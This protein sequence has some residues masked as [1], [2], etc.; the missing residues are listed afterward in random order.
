[1][2]HL[3]HLLTGALWLGSASAAGAVDLPSKPP[4]CAPPP[5]TVLNCG[6]PC[7]VN[8]M[9]SDPTQRDELK[10]AVAR[11]NTTVF[12]GPDVD[13]NFEGL[14]VDWFPITFGRC[15]TLT[16]V[17]TFRTRPDRW[18][19]SERRRPPLFKRQQARSPRSRGPVLRYGRSRGGQAFLHLSCSA[20]VFAGDHA[21]IAGFQLIGP[22]PGQQSTKEIGINVVA[23]KDV[24]I[25]N[26]EISGWAEQ[27]V[28]IRDRAGEDARIDNFGQVVVSDSFIHHNQ[29]PS[30]DGHSGGYGVAVSTGA[31]AT[32]TR[33]V[34]DHNRHSIEA[35][36]DSGGYAAVLNLQLKGG[37]IHQGFL[38]PYTHAFD[39]HGTGNDWWTDGMG[40]DAGELFIYDSNAFQYRKDNAIKIRGKPKKDALITRN[41]FAHPG[42][43]DDWG[44]DAVNLNT[45][46][47]VTLGPGNIINHDTF[48]QYGICDFDGDAIDDLFLA[49]GASFW[50]SSFGE[51]HW[52]FLSDRR[53]QLKDVRLGYFDSDN[54]CDV[55]V[56]DGDQWAYLRSG[57]GAP[58]PLGSF[59]YL[60]KDVVFGRFDPTSRDHRIN[61]TRPTTH[62]FR[63]ETNGQWYVTPLSGANWTPAASSGFPM[64][65]FKFGDFTGDGVTD[66]LAVV[67]GRWHISEGAHGNWRK[68]NN[69]NGDS[70]SGL[71]VANLDADDNVDDLL[72]MS[73]G[74][75]VLSASPRI[76]RV[77]LNWQRSRNGTGRWE[78]LKSYVFTYQAGWEKVT[79]GY[80]MAGRF[81]AAPGGAILTI[82]PDRRGLFYGPSERQVGAN[83]DWS[84]LHPY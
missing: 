27:G 25:G 47:N 23:C 76:V 77:T 15:V 32:I 60:L 13:L 42:F 49:T 37:G 43:E 65:R 48:G 64:D 52:S 34:F 66:V 51:F 44:D 50:F 35:A 29:H 53:D 74:T 36:G 82:D 31:W 2:K 80:A 5:G 19:G 20:T 1:M 45:T 33:N 9:T 55:L 39:I 6:G 28:M 84:S 10:K 57:T 8:I 54:R 71:L 38:N 4:E 26:M 62:A 3:F 61:V 17:N 22:S 7:V 14:P 63:R 67:S 16:S 58:V 68:L 40:G 24:Q 78:P 79:P 59:G 70:V 21:R 12:L 73:S 56:Q 72:K 81:G 75:Q 83:P 11:D 18:D 30:V 46:E 41:V 69:Y